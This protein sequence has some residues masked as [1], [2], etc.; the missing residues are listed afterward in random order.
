MPRRRVME[1]R[2]AAAPESV[3]DLTTAQLRAEYLVEGL[4][5]GDEV[6]LAYS[7]HDRLVIGGGAPAGGP[8][9]LPAPPELGTPG[10][11]DRRELGVV[12]VGGAGVVTVAG[13]PFELG[14]REVLYVGRG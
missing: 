5:D 1:V 8:V 10:F 12:N 6:R 2:R 13:E 9:S 7:H 11:L 3:I 14:P 4:T